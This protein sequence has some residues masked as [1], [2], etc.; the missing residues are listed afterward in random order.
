MPFVYSG[1]EKLKTKHTM[2]LVIFNLFYVEQVL[3]MFDAGFFP[4]L[5]RKYE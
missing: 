1:N 2:M 4:I 3:F 5:H